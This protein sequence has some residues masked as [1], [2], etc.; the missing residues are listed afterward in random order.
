M[1]LSFSEAHQAFRQEVRDWIQ[2][3][4]PKNI[5]EKAEMSGQFSMEEIM[6]WHK[7]LYEKG[8]AAPHWP[9]QYG[10]PGFDAAQRFIFS[11][12]MALAG[13]PGLSPFGLS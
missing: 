9:E 5:K 7:V 10:G 3:S 6:Q 8:W 13:A 12:E 1:D 11:E 4:M 2:S